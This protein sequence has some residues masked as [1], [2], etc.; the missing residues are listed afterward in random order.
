MKELEIDERFERA[1]P[2]LTSEEFQKLEE[3]ILKDR[4]IYNPILIWDNVIIDGHSR[5]D[6]AKRNK[7]EFETKEISFESAEDAIAWIKE[8]A[9]SQRNLNDYQQSKL[10]LELEG[11][12][13][14]KAK[15]KEQQ[16]KTTKVIL[17]KS[18]LAPINVRD[19]LAKKAGVSG[20]TIDKV[21][22][23]ES[24]AT[25]ETKGQLEKGEISINKAYNEIVEPFHELTPEINILENAASSLE[26]WI[27]KHN[28][29]IVMFEF[30]STVYQLIERI[31]D[32]KATYGK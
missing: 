10:V 8:N 5:Y 1:C 6:I 14:A 13:K 11:Y 23:I 31:R 7:I 19:E 2:K 16:R 3:L 27:T 18:E 30:I 28:S 9:I 29:E 24:E 22:K 21:K 15:D 32:K 12:Y 20:R 17:P 26:R 25:D 4:V